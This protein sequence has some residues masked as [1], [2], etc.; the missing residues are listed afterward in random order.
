M[1]TKAANK[2]KRPTKDANA[3]PKRARKNEP[4]PARSQRLE[5]F[6]NMPEDVFNE[7]TQ[8]LDPRDLLS[9]SKTS[10]GFRSVAFVP[11]RKSF[12]RFQRDCVQRAHVNIKCDDIPKK[13]KALYD[14]KLL[15]VVW[16]AAALGLAKPVPQKPK[17][18]RKLKEWWAHEE[19]VKRLLK[20]HEEA[21]DKEEWMKNKTAELFACEKAS[22]SDEETWKQWMT[23]EKTYI[24][25]G[26]K[27]VIM[28][29]LADLG[30][31]EE[32]QDSELV[33]RVW[34][35]ACKML[36][37]EVIDKAWAK[38]KNELQDVLL[39]NRREKMLKQRRIAIHERTAL[40]QVIYDE[41]TGRHPANE[42]IAPLHVVKKHE[43]AF[44]RYIANTPIE[45][46]EAD[47]SKALKEL[48]NQRVPELSKQWLQMM[49]EWLQMISG[50]TNK[51]PLNMSL[52]KM[53]FTCDCGSVMQY[54]AVFIHECVANELTHDDG[55]RAIQILELVGK[56]STTTTVDDM[57][58]L[59]PVF[60][61]LECADR[62]GTQTT[63]TL[64]NWRGAVRHLL[65][66]QDRKTRELKLKLLQSNL[67]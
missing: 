31:S 22:F 39:E 18:P 29:K 7:I 28:S 9:L 58:A 62:Y 47:V 8:H 57:D 5:A 36:N 1:P 66:C 48:V 14:M 23:K 59:D 54:S 50:G 67:S 21:N 37:N 64:L 42:V 6:L 41:Y 12:G 46:A 15:D 2:R 60:E 24:V 11:S 55:G 43:P 25:E 49:D 51:L 56:D 4:E 3:V 26:R 20:E 38:G 13:I 32:L 33:E 65:K 45:V 19:T 40:L 53:F 61:C 35:A 63:R 44:E 34:S 30:W 16:N 52:A 27:K 17:A 10:K